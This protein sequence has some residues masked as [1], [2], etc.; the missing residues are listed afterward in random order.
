MSSIKSGAVESGLI[1]VSMCFHCSGVRSPLRTLRESSSD[2]ATTKR[3]ISCWALISSEK[4]ATPFSKSTATFRASESTKAV[5]PIDGR[6]AMMIRSD[7]CH[8]SV[9]RSRCVNPDGTPLN[10]PSRLEASSIICSVLVRMSRDFCTSRLTCPSATLKISPSAK[11][12]RS[13]TSVASSNDFFWISVVARISSRWTYFW[14]MI[15]A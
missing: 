12:I 3:I 8:P 14:A 15:F 9:S 11:S 1:A 4:N 2:S 6:A 13:V 5:L 10:P 7:G